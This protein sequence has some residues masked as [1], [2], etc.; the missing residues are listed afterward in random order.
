MSGDTNVSVKAVFS[1]AIF[2]FNPTERS[3]LVSILQLSARR[4][5]SFVAA[6]DEA[7]HLADIAVVDCDD[8]AAVEQFRRLR[9]GHTRSAVLVGASSHGLP[10][11][12]LPRPMQWIRLLKVLDTAIIRQLS[13]VP[14]VPGAGKGREAEDGRRPGDTP[15]ETPPEAPRPDPRDVSTW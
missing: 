15:P 4:A 10:W 14:A 7:R 2:G 13:L 12:L 6:P 8:L 5:P 11:P 3:A 1:V 9:A